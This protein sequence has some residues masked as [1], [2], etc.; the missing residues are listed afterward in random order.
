MFITLAKGLEMVLGALV[1][2]L[3]LCRDIDDISLA[4]FYIVM[5]KN[6]N[7]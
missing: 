6:K 3:K 1:F 2:M 7:L 5:I 4:L